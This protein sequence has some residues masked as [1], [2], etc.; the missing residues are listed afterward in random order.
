MRAHCCSKLFIE[1]KPWMAVFSVAFDRGVRITATK[2]R[3]ARSHVNFSS[4]F[5]SSTESIPRVVIFLNSTLLHW[6]SD[7]KA[8][9]RSCKSR[10]SHRVPIKL[11]SDV[12]V[13]MTYKIW[14]T[15]SPERHRWVRR[16][17]EHAT[18]MVVFRLESIEFIDWIAFLC[19]IL[20]TVKRRLVMTSRTPPRRASNPTSRLTSL[21][22]WP[23]QAIRIRENSKFCLY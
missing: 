13:V 11:R 10:K 23:L 20:K 14:K 2:N 19:R 15:S 12:W 7:S 3:L 22:R 9:Y 18:L 4:L 17:G 16:M 5:H 1:E 6:C 8:A 21:S